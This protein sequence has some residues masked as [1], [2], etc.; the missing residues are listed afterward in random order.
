MGADYKNPFLNIL[1][2]NL[3]ELYGAIL[4]D[5]CITYKPD[6]RVYTLEIVGN[7]TEEKDYYQSIASVLEKISGKTPKIIVRHEK[8]GTSLRL[9]LHSKAFLQFLMNELELDGKP[10]TKTVAIPQKFLSWRIA[11]HIIRGLFETDGSLYFTRVKN[12]P[13]YPRIEIK[14]KS[15]RMAFQLQDILNDNG[16]IVN[17]RQCRPENVF[18]IY[19]SGKKMCEK[20]VRKIGFSSLKNKTKYELWK[21]L[22]FYIPWSSLIDR[23]K[24]LRR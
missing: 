5:G 14:T 18:G 21:R 23:Q 13:T 10:K 2:M 20:W 9:Y 19:I 3:Y 24:C 7:A 22:G 17:R 6:L 16:F 4:G 11:K 12:I 15:H 8:K 1:M